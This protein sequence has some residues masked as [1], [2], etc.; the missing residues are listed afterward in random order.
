MVIVSLYFDDKEYENIKK[1]ADLYGVSTT[2]FIKNSI[3]ED[4]EDELDYIGAIQSERV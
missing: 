4:L 1:V 2:D 3:L